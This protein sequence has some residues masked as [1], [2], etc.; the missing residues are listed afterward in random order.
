MKKHVKKYRYDIVV[1][2]V[3]ALLIGAIYIQKE[4]FG[5]FSDRD[6]FQEF[7]V[8]LGFLGPIVIIGTIVLE[9]IIAPIPGFIPAITA[10]FMFGP[11]FGAIYTY[12]GNVIGTVIVFFLAR[13]YGKKLLHWF[14]Q[15]DR[16]EKYGKTIT[17]HE[18][19]LLFF[20]FF[21]ILPV[22]IITTAFGLSKICKKKFFVVSSVGF[23]FYSI[24]STN[25]GDY[26][27]KFWFWS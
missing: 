12:I 4:Q 18:N 20:Y 24:V 15:K 7:V 21:P 1:F 16:L 23:V 9:V 10:G 17:R 22:D 26:L 8:G 6:A 13:K 19:Y 25:F 5:I 3:L 14:E 2:I 11:I 27:A